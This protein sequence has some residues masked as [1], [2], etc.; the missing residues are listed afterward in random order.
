MNSTN[1][2]ST[3]PNKTKQT[4]TTKKS[5]KTKSDKTKSET[6]KKSDKKTN[7]FF[8]EYVFKPSI[9]FMPESIKSEAKPEIPM[10]GGDQDVVKSD[11]ISNGI[12]YIGL[13]NKQNSICYYLT[14]VQRL[15]SSKTLSKL[16]KDLDVGEDHPLKVV[17]LYD[18]I[19]QNNKELVFSSIRSN[20]DNMFDRVFHPDMLKGGDPYVVLKL[21]F[22]PALIEKLG[23]EN[24]KTVL[25]EMNVE[26]LNL[27]GKIDD[28]FISDDMRGAIN[29]FRDPVTN[30][31]YKKLYSDNV[32]QLI[33]Y[34]PY[35]SAPF[36]ICN[37]NLFFN[38]EEGNPS[39]NGGHAVALIKDDV[40]DFYVID[41]SVNIRKVENYIG[42]KPNRFYLIEFKD[43]NDENVRLLKPLLGEYEKLDSRIYKTVIKYPKKE[44]GLNG[45][46][47]NDFQNTVIN[48]MN[49]NRANFADSIELEVV[50]VDNKQNRIHRIL[51]SVIIVLVTI[52]LIVVIVKLIMFLSL[53][54]KQRDLKEK[55]NK[56]EKR[57]VKLE[58]KLGVESYH[59]SQGEDINTNIENVFKP[60]TPGEKIKNIVPEVAEIGLN[61]AEKYSLIDLANKNLMNQII[62]KSTAN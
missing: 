60:M 42:S 43:I 37:M 38:D 1:S 11:I 25:S 31:K 26:P 13:H 53:K 56:N 27:G 32:N 48:Q 22:I 2:K 33:N 45:G 23:I 52:L 55:Y 15:H 24:T 19:N 44:N 17:K 5:D 9:I 61:I 54:K 39:Q 50:P 40:N 3:K 10:S 58:K 4:K 35:T 20:L 49:M 46:G 36:S 14:M 16:I 59:K 30:D 62:R 29:V 7:R 18:G 34:T 6:T 51:Y 12:L 57:I 21:I 41:D 47:V 28:G 8:K